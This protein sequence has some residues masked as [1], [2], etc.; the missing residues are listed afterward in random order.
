MAIFIT[1]INSASTNV[2]FNYLDSEAV[3][4]RTLSCSY[5]FDISDVSYTDQDDV[6]YEGIDALNRVYLQ[7][8]IV[9]KIG[10]DEIRNG[11]V[12]SISYPESLSVG[13][14]TAS[15]SIEERQRVDS[16]GSLSNVINNIPSPQ[17][18]ESFSESFSFERG[19]NYYSSSRD[20]SLKYKQDAG[21]FFLDKAK[22]FVQSIFIDSRP[23]FG[24]QQDGISEKARFNTYI[25][26]IITEKIDLL[27]KSVSFSEN[28]NINRL[29]DSVAENSSE[30]ITIDISI[31]NNGYTNKNYNANLIALKEP[32]ELNILNTV[33]AFLDKTYQENF[34]EFKYPISISR[35]I[36]SDGGRASVSISFSNN[37]SL[38]SIINAN[39]SVSKTKAESYDEYTFQ[40]SISSRGP[41]KNASFLNSKNY[42]INNFNIGLQKIPL[43]F[44]EVN[45]NNLYEKSRSVSF[46]KFNR[47]INETVVYST[48]PQ[49]QI[50][51]DIL[52]KNVEISDNLGV[53]RHTLTPILAERIL[54]RERAGSKTISDRSISVNLTSKT[55]KS[56]ENNAL[57]ICETYHPNSNYYYIDSKTSKFDPINGTSSASITYL[58]FN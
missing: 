8:N 4:G 17:D 45:S 16:Y 2:S 37:P 33:S 29:N 26:P 28:I 21:N 56:L 32:L 44:T 20:V 5:D 41:N 12:T 34:Q 47:I 10:S 39:Y 46:E 42:W 6:L 14:T 15:I 51:G 36:N 50:N 53:T 13:K 7:K 24:Y 55:F 22:I 25:K 57:S 49:Y 11:L 9:G 48:D 35:S 30:E 18:V 3:W 19:Q 31:D 54:L 52:N 40:N 23:S 43:L 58:Y 27:N 1:K 38:N